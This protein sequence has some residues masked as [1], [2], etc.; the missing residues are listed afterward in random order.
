[1]KRSLCLTLCLALLVTAAAVQAETG[2]MQY[3]Y[4][5]SGA[6]L[7]GAFS[8]VGSLPLQ[9]FVP[10]TMTGSDIRETGESGGL[11]LFLDRPDIPL[12][13]FFSYYPKAPVPCTQKSVDEFRA[14]GFYSDY[15]L[16]NGMPAVSFFYEETGDDGTVWSYEYTYYGLQG[17]SCLLEVRKY[18]S[19][20]AD[21]AAYELD[22]IRYSVSRVD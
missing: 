21:Q 10:D 14:K 5:L 9:V 13:V 7:N 6:D 19:G 20:N 11:V 8:P 12:Y 2:G 4:W 3:D 22:C 15:E 1:M 17:G 16:I 18:P